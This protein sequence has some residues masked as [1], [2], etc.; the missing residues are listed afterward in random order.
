[1]YFVHNHKNR[2]NVLH[3]V[4]SLK[5]YI[6]I[7]YKFEGV[8]CPFNLIFEIK[9]HKFPTLIILLLYIKMSMKEIFFT[10]YEF[11]P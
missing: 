5:E 2:E 6:D 4:L 8:L 9:R 7:E 10:L 1:M 3:K 11:Y